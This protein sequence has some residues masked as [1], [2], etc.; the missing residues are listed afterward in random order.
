MKKMNQS[1]RKT[2]AVLLSIVFSSTVAFGSMPTVAY[3]ALAEDDEVTLVFAVGDGAVYNNDEVNNNY[4]FDD[5]AY[6]YTATSVVTETSEGAE[7]TLLAEPDT[8]PKGKQFVG[9]QS[10]DGAW[11]ESSRVPLSALDSAESGTYTFTAVYNDYTVIYDLDGGAISAESG[12]FLNPDDPSYARAGFDEEAKDTYTPLTA[13]GI[14]AMKSGYSEFVGWALNG[15]TS[16]MVENFADYGF[17]TYGDVF[18]LQAIYGSPIDIGAI[19]YCNAFDGLDEIDELSDIANDDLIVVE[20]G[21]SVYTVE[22][23][24]ISPVP[25]DESTPRGQEFTSWDVYAVSDM[26]NKLRAGVTSFDT[27]GQTADLVF[28]ASFADAVEGS[29]IVVE[30]SFAQ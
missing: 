20:D 23:G 4:T 7:V 16:N 17:D 30:H 29:S 12:L 6:T 13:D 11:I 14:A 28:V 15:N 10:A 18:N 3:A 8:L 19:A 25:N 9:W 2:I 24:E 1:I 21:V 27:T 22:T 26:T 5:E